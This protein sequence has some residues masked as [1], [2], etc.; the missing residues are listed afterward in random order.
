M[1]LRRLLNWFVMSL[2]LF[3]VISALLFVLVSL[4][5]GDAARVIVGP[6]ASQ[7]QYLKVREELGLDLPLW[8]QYGQ[9]LGQLLQGDLG[10]SVVS[11][12]PVAQVLADR[13]E[14]TLSLIILTFVCAS[15]LGI[16]LGVIGA[17][18][19]GIV[20]KAADIGS[21]IGSAVPSFWIGLVLA[22]IFAVQLQWLP[23]SGYSP[24]V[25]GL[26]AWL[27]HLIL[28]VATLTIGGT[29]LLAKQTRDAVAEQLSQPYILLLRAHGVSERR[30]LWRHALRG[31]AVPIVTIL[32]MKMIGLTTGTVLVESVF[33]IPGFAG[34]A[35]NATLLHDIPVV[36][37]IALIFTVVIIITNL[38]V[39]LLYS[40]LN[41]K[42]ASR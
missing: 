12:V 39:E 17:A 21:V 8:Q 33:V 32:G 24:L 1:S 9:W 31:A 27:V 34:Y 7:E 13:I 40:R 20:G 41:V 28:P 11:G 42:E 23:T 25:D 29:A 37:A 10:D 16:V 14:A 36:Q 19:P 6:N 4:T 38:V 15:I 22:A 30:I 26:G 35:V 3:F 18:R 2:I 5:P